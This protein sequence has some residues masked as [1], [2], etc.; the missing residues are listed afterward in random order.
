[1]FL[2][3]RS[4]IGVSTNFAN[5]R[6]IFEHI[7]QRLLQRSS[8]SLPMHSQYTVL[9]IPYPKVFHRV[10][11]AIPF[12]EQAA[13]LLK[14]VPRHSS[15]IHVQSPMSAITAWT[16]ALSCKVSNTESFSALPR[17]NQFS[18]AYTPATSRK[19]RGGLGHRLACCRHCCC[20]VQRHSSSF[21]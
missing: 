3:R 10:E 17:S 13:V 7:E 14:E 4:L 9:E 8:W 12:Y 19:L 2:P 21:R 18:H 1:M 20:R 11:D 15:F 5:F 16:N 6:S